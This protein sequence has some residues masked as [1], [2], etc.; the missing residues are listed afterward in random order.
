MHYVYFL[1]SKKL[2]KVY[3][4][5]TPDIQARVA[6]H[7]AGLQRYTKIGTPWILIGLVPFPTKTSALQEEK[8]LKRCKNKQYYKWYIETNSV[9]NIPK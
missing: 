5:Y 9:K 7:N 2:Q 6:Y 1:W 8:R 3:I 4:G